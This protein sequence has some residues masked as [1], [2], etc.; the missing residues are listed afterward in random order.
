MD[1][2]STNRHSASAGPYAHRELHHL[3]SRCAAHLDE[4]PYLLR[5][6][7]HGGGGHR[8]HPRQ[9]STGRV[10][11]SELTSSDCRTSHTCLGP[12]HCALSHTSDPYRTL[13]RPRTL[14]V[15][16]RVPEKLEMTRFSELLHYFRP[17]RT[18]VPCAWIAHRIHSN[19]SLLW[20][21]RTAGVTCPLSHPAS[22][23]RN[24]TLVDPCSMPQTE[25]QTLPLAR[26]WY[27]QPCT[28]DLPRRQVQDSP[29]SPS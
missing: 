13:E 14:L 9:Q 27:L 21:V 5:V 25:P 12:Y 18:R 24:S 28:L 4:V 3:G 16:Q 11:V 6:C 8:G 19:A 7:R 17:L 20:A 2:A 29:F 1:V 15:A 23:S 26:M 22:S 10:Q